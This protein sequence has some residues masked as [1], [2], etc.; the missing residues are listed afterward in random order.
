MDNEYIKIIRQLKEG[1]QKNKGKGYCYIY[2]TINPIP[3][4][5]DVVISIKNK[6]PERSVLICLEQYKYKGE[7]RQY[8]IDNNLDEELYYKQIQFLSH[9]YMISNNKNR[10]VFISLGINDDEEELIRAINM[11]K[12]SLIIFTKSIMNNK[13]I[14]AINEHI[15]QIPIKLD[16]EKLLY[17]K[18]YSPVK[19]YRHYV[20]LNEDDRELYNKYDKYIKDSI[21]IFGSLQQIERCR[22]G[23]FETRSSAIDECYKVAY[24]NGW[25]SEL[26]MSLEYNRQLD[27]LFNPNAIKERVNTIFNI[28]N[29]RK[30]L[31]ADNDAKLETIKRIIDENENKKILIVSLRGEFC[32]RITKYLNEECDKNY[33]ALGYHNELEDSYL[34]GKDGKV[35]VWKSGKQKGEPRVF[36]AD[37][38]SSNNEAA[39]KEGYTKILCIKNSSKNT[40]EI[41][42]DIIILT[43][44]LIDD[45]FKI[46]RRFDKIKFQEP[47]IVHRIYCKD[48]NEEKSILNEKPSTLIEVCESDIEKNLFYD[49]NSGDIIL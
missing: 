40:L 2:E 46:K 24:S 7:Y 23:N 11:H 6:N 37:F 44:T 14:N 42:V 31:V 43:T 13:F 20:L 26:D 15:S 38:L 45:I 27:E 21:S 29:N 16:N 48:T 1:F 9:S 39:F 34:T 12:F 4:I 41:D 28:T 17:K 3:A 22:I 36:K 10:D 25:T 32:N 35:V 47:T 49:E 5:V 8:I 19:E 30:K 33:M 18:I